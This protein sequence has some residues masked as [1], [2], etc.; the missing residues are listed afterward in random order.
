[1]QAK[2]H[3]GQNFL[4]S[5]PARIS[6]VE[7]GNVT[8][9]DTVLEIGPGKGFLTEELLKTKAHII[10]LEKDRDLIPILEKQ[11]SSHKNFSLLEGDALTFEPHGGGYK[12]IA[13]IPY[14]ITGAIFERYLSH[15]HQPTT[16]VVLI[17]KEVAERIVANNKKESILSLSVKAYGEPKLVKK[18]S[19]GSF[20]PAPNVDSAI[21]AI[22]NISR[23]KFENQY[24]EAMFFRVVKTGFAH[25]RKMLLSNLKDSF[26]KNNLPHIFEELGI[27]T[28]ARAEDIPISLWLLLAKELL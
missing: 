18:V 9:K 4:T 20:N 24:H 11:F 17:Q 23:K 13:N 26:P 27:S 6:I 7:A 28:K 3:L 12:L 14:Y 25:K 2:K 1:M 15:I 10:A 16:M 21:L 5:V 8:P 22:Y 19:R